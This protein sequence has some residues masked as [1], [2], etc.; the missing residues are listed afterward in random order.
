MNFSSLYDT[1]NSF[2]ASYDTQKI[3][4]NFLNIEYFPTFFSIQCLFI[5]LTIRRHAKKLSWAKSLMFCSLMVHC[6]RAIAAFI[7]YRPNPLLQ[8]THY[9]PTFLVIWFLVNAS[10]FDIVHRVC[11]FPPT[12]VL[13]QVVYAV[14]QTRQ[15]VNGIE[16]AQLQYPNSLT[17]IILISVVLSSTE[18][19]IFIITHQK[20]RDFSTA[21]L[22]RNIAAAVALVL[23]KNYSEYFDKIIKFSTGDLQLIILAFNIAIA[24]MNDIV[25]GLKSNE[26]VDVTL[27][28]YFIRLFPY[29]GSEIESNN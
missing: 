6:G 21:V 19:F 22:S 28:T 2:L 12:L 18:S 10:P 24:I 27:L 17:G 14:I 1:V 3:T 29:F 13:L 8:N 26:S 9:F 16:L 20:S 11:N 5:C 25:Y 4:S 23:H 15:V 7:C